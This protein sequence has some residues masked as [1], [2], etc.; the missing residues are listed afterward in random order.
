MERD[1]PRKIAWRVSKGGLG[2]FQMQMM[3]AKR[4]VILEMLLDGR[5]R[6]AG[7]LHRAENEKQLSDDMRSAEHTYELQSLMRNSY[8]DYCLKQQKNTTVYK[9]HLHSIY[10]HYTQH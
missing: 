9:N 2:Q 10:Q 1:L 5:L 7:I 8:A 6:G 4:P 3:R